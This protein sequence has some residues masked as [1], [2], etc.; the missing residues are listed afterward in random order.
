MLHAEQ[1]L[2]ACA[3][4]I[5]G[6]E[7]GA[8]GTPHLQGAVKFHNRQRF[9]AVQKL[10]PDEGVHWEVMKKPWKLNVIYCKKEMAGDWSKIHGN[11]PEASRFIG[12]EKRLMDAM[13][14]PVIWRT[15]QQE[16]IDIIKHTEPNR[17]V[18][19]FW[20]PTGKAG[21]TYLAKWL[22]MN[23]DCILGGGRATDVYYQVAKF[24]EDNDA[25]DPKLILLDIPRSSQ[26]FCNYA[27]IEKLADGM[28][29]SG[30][31]EGGIFL[32]VPPHVIVFANEPPAFECMSKDRWSVKQLFPARTVGQALCRPGE[33]ANYIP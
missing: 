18:H 7:R 5:F 20:E 3:R 10:F 32:W 26:K 1:V 23:Y 9:T 19:W 15:W 16:V 22:Y 4:F 17:Q 6:E 8:S 24:Y 33:S 21:K 29:Q 13:Y 28:V 31:Y 27:A 25:T 12:R 14:S 2:G 11:I 30:K